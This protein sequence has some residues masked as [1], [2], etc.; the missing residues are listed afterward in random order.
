MDITDDLEVRQ[1][2]DK[3]VRANMQFIIDKYIESLDRIP[4]EYKISNLSKLRGIAKY[5]FAETMDEDIK[6]M[7]I[8][9]MNKTVPA[10]YVSYTATEDKDGRIELAVSDLSERPIKMQNFFVHEV[11][12]AA[13]MFWKGSNMVKEFNKLGLQYQFEQSKIVLKNNKVEITFINNGKDGILTKITGDVTEFDNIIS[14]ILQW[15]PDSNFDNIAKTVKR[16]YN[17]FNLISPIVGNVLFNAAG[18]DTVSNFGQVQ[19]LARVLSRIY[20]ADTLSVIKNA[21]NNNLPL[22]Q[23]VSLAYRL[24]DIKRHIIDDRN[25]YYEQHGEMTSSIY[26]HNVVYLNT[27]KFMS[28]RLRTDFVYDNKKSTADKVNEHDLMHVAFLGDFLQGIVNTRSMY[29]GANSTSGIIYIQPHCFSDKNRHFMVP[30]NLNSDWNL[31]QYH[32]G[33]YS[34]STINLYLLLQ[35]LTKNGDVKSLNPIYNAIYASRKSS[36]ESTVSN[37]IYDYKNAGFSIEGDTLEEQWSSLKTL[38]GTTK[39]KSAIRT[40]FYNNG[41][42]FIEEIH[43]SNGQ[44]NN[45]IDAIFRK[46]RS[47]EAFNTYLQSQLSEFVNEFEQA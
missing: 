11:I 29:D 12:N 17:K 1:E 13:S 19:S 15:E 38:L 24:R 43:I 37:I 2:I 44:V 5:I 14:H 26:D 7:F 25:S 23:L 22:F 41:I 47:N 42:E 36:I 34:H 30:I 35:G 46:T 4:D 16:N 31:P 8:H 45:Q 20:G 27:D 33:T 9:I 28:P 18:I 32:N 39:D 40:A 3:G 21:D 6:A 10:T